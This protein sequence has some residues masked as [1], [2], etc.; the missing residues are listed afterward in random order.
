MRHLVVPGLLLSLSVVSGCAGETQETPEDRGQVAVF[1]PEAGSAS[2]VRLHA[3]R[4][5]TGRV[6]ARAAV[7][8]LTT[9]FPTRP[10]DTLR[11]DACAPGEDLD[12]VL[13]TPTLV[14]VHFVNHGAAQCDL[15]GDGVVVLEQQLAWTVGAA[16]GSPRVPVVVTVGDDERRVL[17]PVRAEERYLTP[18]Q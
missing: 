16:T 18:T 4:V 12:D 13:V 15:S 10:F 1:V 11:S 14:T 3:F 6:G 7:E 17:G 5:S 9:Y 2:G 8:A